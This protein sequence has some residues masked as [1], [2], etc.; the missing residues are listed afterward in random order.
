MSLFTRRIRINLGIAGIAAALMGLTACNNPTSAEQSTGLKAEAPI[1]IASL[2][3]PA[4]SGGPDFTSGMLVAAARINAEG[5]IDGRKVEVKVFKQDGTPSGIVNAYRAAAADPTVIGAMLGVAGTEIKRLSDQVKLPVA[6]SGGAEEI[7][8]PP[9]KYV[10]DTTFSTEYAGSALAHAMQT[11]P[12]AKRVAIL[13]YDA[14]YSQSVEASV[15]QNCEHFGCEVVAVE[16][17]TS[18][19]STDE[20]IPQLTKLREAKP[21]FFYIEGLNPNGWKA[22]RQL[23]IKEP[24]V[25]EQWL[26]VPAIAGAC[27]ENCAGVPFAAHKC[28]YNGNWDQLN[29]DDPVVEW[30]KGF[31]ADWE[32]ANPGKEFPIFSIYGY[33]AVAVLSQGV[34]QLAEADK[35]IT[36]D[37]LAAEMANFDGAPFTSTGVLHSSPQNHKLTGDWSDGY[38]MTVV[39]PGPDGKV[40]FALAEGADPA[41]AP[42]EP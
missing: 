18:A 23:G 36:R 29:A 11:H 3:A 39:K 38:V 6:T 24:I 15:R 12:G 22:V 32:K 41:G 25:S 31:V 13:H 16:S 27:A 30:C 33:D 19:A 35:A 2:E 5:G 34:K 7:T 40:G 26:A 10:F 28:R 1:V 37:G 42:L 8:N 21:D 20:I 14:A 9:A 17:S 4:T